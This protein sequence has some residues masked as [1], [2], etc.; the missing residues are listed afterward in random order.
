MQRFAANDSQKS[1]LGGGQGL[2]VEHVNIDLFVAN[3]PKIDGDSQRE[4]EAFVGSDTRREH[5][6]VDVTAAGS[7]V[8]S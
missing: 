7:L 6:Q 3:A 8:N 4:P 2:G 1:P 5:D